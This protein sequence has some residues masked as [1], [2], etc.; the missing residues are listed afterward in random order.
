MVEEMKAL[1]KNHIWDL[2]ET[3]ND[4]AVIGN[5]W[6]Y[7]LNQPTNGNTLRYRTRILAWEGIDYGETLS[8]VV[9]FDSITATLAITASENLQMQQFDVKTAFLYGNIEEDIYM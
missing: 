5:R 3:P 1:A 2:V 4:R 7:K 8:P 6:I 9:R